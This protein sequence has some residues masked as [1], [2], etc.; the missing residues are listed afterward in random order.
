[1]KSLFHNLLQNGLMY[2]M[3]TLLSS[4]SIGVVAG[5]G[6]HPLPSPLFT[7]IGVFAFQ[8]VWQRD[9]A[10]AAIEVAPVLL[11]NECEMP[12]QSLFHCGRKHGV[13]VFVAFAGT[14][15]YMVTDEIDIFDPQLQTFN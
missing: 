4:H 5:C 11:L 13:S 8:C 7:R 2:V 9:S 15:N 6:K 14:H 3:S 10:Q 1:M 12:S